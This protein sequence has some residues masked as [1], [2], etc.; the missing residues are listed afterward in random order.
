MLVTPRDILTLLESRCGGLHAAEAENLPLELH[1]LWDWSDVV[2]PVF[3]N[4]MEDKQKKTK[5]V[6]VEIN[7]SLL[8]DVTADSVLGSNFYPQ[9]CEE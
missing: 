7:D 3:F 2:V 6:K 9:E 4:L 8:V 5:R 1:S